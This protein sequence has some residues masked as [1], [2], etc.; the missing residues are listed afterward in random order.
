M[1]PV[2]TWRLYNQLPGHMFYSCSVTYSIWS[3]IILLPFCF[4]SFLISQSIQ[5][6][7]LCLCIILRVPDVSIN[8]I[9]NYY[10]C[11]IRMWCSKGLEMLHEYHFSLHQQ[12]LLNIF[13]LFLHSL[14]G[15]LLVL[16]FQNEN[17]A[18]QTSC[19]NICQ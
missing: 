13:P 6:S 8:R 11:K 16:P 15:Q 12:P 19:N 9:T 10:V 5:L 17:I 18:V 14:L 3:Y 7:P 2:H 4:L 1:L